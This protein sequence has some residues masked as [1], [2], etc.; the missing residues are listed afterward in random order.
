MKI[1]YSNGT[2][3]TVVDF[4]AAMASVRATH[5]E[6]VAYQDGGEI[7]DNDDVCSGSILIWADEASSVND[8]GVCAVAEIEA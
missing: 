1:K 8:D 6:A 7:Y 2:T 5:P 3:E 4:E